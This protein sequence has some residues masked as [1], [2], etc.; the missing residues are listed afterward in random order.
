MGHE[1]VFTPG[2]LVG[3]VSQISSV[4]KEAVDP[5][6]GV[7]ALLSRVEENYANWKARGSH[8][9]EWHQSM[10]PSQVILLKNYLAYYHDSAVNYQKLAYQASQLAER[11]EKF[12]RLTFWGR[13]RYLVTGKLL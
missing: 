1:Q 7:P 13:L 6:L 3:E 9:K 11:L 5:V 2:V 10:V 4:P 12:E 8:P